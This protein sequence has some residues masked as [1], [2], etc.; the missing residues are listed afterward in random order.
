MEQLK[1]ALTFVAKVARSMNMNAEQHELLTKHLNEIAVA[2][3]DY[4]KLKLGNGEK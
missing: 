3:E 1:L 2:L 4:A